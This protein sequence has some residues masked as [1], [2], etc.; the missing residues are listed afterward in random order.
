MFCLLFGGAKWEVAGALTYTHTVSQLT[1]RG[2]ALHFPAACP[3]AKPEC[4]P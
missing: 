4:Q 2:N 1:G 3:K